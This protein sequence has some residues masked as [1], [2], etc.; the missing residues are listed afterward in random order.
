MPSS[1]SVTAIEIENYSSRVLRNKIRCNLPYC[2]V[3]DTL[4]T[5]FTRHRTRPREFFIVR[6][7]LVQA[8]YDRQPKIQMVNRLVLVSAV[9]FEPTPA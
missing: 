3:C 9:S 8:V 4:A 7:A 1:S 5:L 6:K 2:P